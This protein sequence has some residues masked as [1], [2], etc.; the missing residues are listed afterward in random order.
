M[1]SKVDSSY[2]VYQVKSSSQI[3]IF[4]LAY[5]TGMYN[6]AVNLRTIPL[7]ALHK[8]SQRNDE[9]TIF[10]SMPQGVLKLP[11]TKAVATIKV[12]TNNEEI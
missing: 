6:T 10:G 5:V 9:E 4:Y 11:S 7:D 8:P 12:H 2:V 3:D 1:K